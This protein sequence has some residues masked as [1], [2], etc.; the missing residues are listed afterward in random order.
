MLRTLLIAT[1]MLT[2]SGAALAGGHD[3]YGRVILVEPHFSISFGSR[4]RDGFRILY[5]F[6]GHRYWTHSHR[7]PGHYIVLPPHHRFKHG[8][9]LRYDDH[10]WNDYDRHHW[11]GHRR[12]WH[13]DRHRYREHRRH[14]RH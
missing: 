10:G 2:T 5:E 7:Y 12:D 14:D 13:D 8:T 1:A 4:H 6:G 9:P 11:K 3:D